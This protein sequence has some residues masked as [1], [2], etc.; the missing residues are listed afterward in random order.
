MADYLVTA[1][2]DESN[3]VKFFAAQSLGKLK[4]EA[5]VPA[6]L[7]A[8][9]ANHDTDP[10]LRHALV[11]GLAGCATPAQL[12]RPPGMNPAPSASLRCSRSAAKPAPRPPSF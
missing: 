2:K 1:L 5:A 7:A 3:R 6:L 4:S 10:Y 9:R 11:M 12:P 8:V